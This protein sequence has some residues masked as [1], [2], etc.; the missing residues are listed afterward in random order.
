ME[1]LQRNFAWANKTFECPFNSFAYTIN[2]VMHTKFLWSGSREILPRQL[3]L[4]HA[5]LTV[6]P[7]D[8][9]QEQGR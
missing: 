1:E 8:T 6:L 4:L 5:P 3:K 7:V 2:A 9:L